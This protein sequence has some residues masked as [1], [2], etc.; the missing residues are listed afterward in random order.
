MVASAGKTMFTGSFSEFV[1]STLNSGSWLESLSRQ[2]SLRWEVVMIAVVSVVI[3]AG[4]QSALAVVKLLKMRWASEIAV[5]DFS[6]IDTY[7]HT[8]FGHLEMLTLNKEETLQFMCD[9]TVEH[10]HAM[11]VWLGPFHCVLLCHHPST[12]QPILA[13]TEPKDEFVYGLVKPWLGEGLL[14]SEGKKWTRNRK[15][16]TPG[17]HFDILKPYVK[18]FNHSVNTML[19]KWKAKC[20]DGPLE[21]FSNISLMTLDSLLMC[22]FSQESHCQTKGDAHPYIRGVYKLSDLIM[23]RVNFPPFYS[24]A[25][26]HM[27]PEGFRWR[28]ALNEVHGHSKKVIRDRRRVLNEGKKD[29]TRKYVDFLD[30]LLAARDEDGKGLTDQEIQDEVDTFMF[31]GHDTTASSISWCLYNLAT[32][33]QYQEKCRREIDELLDEKEEDEWSWDDLS[34]LTYLT[35]CIKESL[36]LYPA[37]PVTARRLE[38]PLKFPDLDVTVPA[39]QIIAINILG[40]HHNTSVWPDPYTYDPERFSLENSK[41]RR[42]HSYLP[43]SAGP[44]NCIGQNFAMNEMKVC[45]SLILR[46]FTLS[47]DEDAIVR[48]ALMLVLRAEGGLHIKVTPRKQSSDKI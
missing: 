28:R 2:L 33:P 47:V 36:R 41:D 18:L 25:I 34:K 4:M 22:V 45:I 7:R 3:L 11:P 26:Y 24:D 48:R 21:M 10:P 17:F 5:R 30:I 12:L 20:G 9:I 35:M 37:V 6:T 32:H 42:S 29:N 31:E 1:H 44:R 46:N 43:F 14:I 39:G 27:T 13:T 23:K 16:L 38:R 40:L 19:H 15:L 8:I